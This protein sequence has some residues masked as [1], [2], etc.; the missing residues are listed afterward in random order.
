[1]MTSRV[2]AYMDKEADEMFWTKNC[3]GKSGWNAIEF[4]YCYIEESMSIK[5][6]THQTTFDNCPRDLLLHLPIVRVR[7]PLCTGQKQ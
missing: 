1:M 5:D 3:W 7:F 6:A 2:E 4:Q